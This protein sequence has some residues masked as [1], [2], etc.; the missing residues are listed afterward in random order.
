MKRIATLLVLMLIGTAALAG[1]RVEG[2]VGET[3][4]RVGAAR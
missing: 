1:C 2:E 4:A 3:S